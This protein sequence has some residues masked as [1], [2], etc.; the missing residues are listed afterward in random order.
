MMGY[1][2]IGG[3]L[4]SFAQLN[5]MLG[6]I[7][8]VDRQRFY[9]HVVR[10]VGDQPNALNCGEVSFSRSTVISQI[11]TCLPGVVETL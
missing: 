4:E 5:I 1:L 7:G 10:N 8:W 9:L 3:K 2:L 6:I 11:P